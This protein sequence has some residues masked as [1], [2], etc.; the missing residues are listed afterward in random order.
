MRLTSRRATL[1]FAA[2]LVGCIGFSSVVLAEDPAA[3]TAGTGLG[4]ADL[5]PGQPAAADTPP[6]AS[7]SSSQLL[8]SPRALPADAAASEATS[9][10]II[11]RMLG[12]VNQAE[13][14]PT[15][16]TLAEAVH[17]AIRSNPG[18]RAQ[19][20][21]PRRD[22]YTPYGATGAFDPKFRLGAEGNK[23]SAPSASALASGLATTEERSV[24]TDV[25]ISKML[26]SG[27]EFDVSWN[28]VTADTNSVFY[29]INPRY[30]NRLTFSLR[31]PIL[32]NFWAANEN[33]LVLVG[34]S[35]AEESLANFEAELSQFVAGVID[36]YWRYEQ[37]DA[38]LE[39]ARRSVALANE[40]VRDADARVAVGLLA[41]VAVKEAQA[42][43]AARE[44]KAIVAEN[45][46]LVAG[47][48]LQHQVMLGAAENKAAAPILPSEEHNVSKV[49]VDRALSLKT[50][51]ES[52]AEIRGAAYALGS[53]RFEEKRARNALLP[54]LDILGDYSLIGLAGDAK[55]VV[56][57]EG[58]V[59]FSPYD[60]NYGDSL[61][62][63]VNG[64]FHRY[65]VGLE[66]EVPFGN[67]AAKADAAAAEIEVKRA[68]LNL[69]QTVSTVVLDVDRA[70]ADLASAGKRVVASRAARTL[71]EEN[72]RN[73]T[74]RF[75][76]GAVT[77]KDVLDF[78]EKLAAAMASEVRAITDHAL[79]VTRLRLADG[80]LLSRFGIEVENPDA[81]GLPWWYQF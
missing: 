37:A 56:D 16:L 12:E 14:K 31:Q 38:E 71:A 5:P 22:A 10:R 7:A 35:R 80:T 42:D 59:Q 29:L 40:L 70:I 67:A 64:D 63:M 23:I 1:L 66:L 45:D 73:Q 43:A 8:A 32:R 11:E 34:R 79:S 74:R 68:S 44:E 58:N 30:E 65:G 51:I 78:Q 41:P 6:D 4:V 72:L 49:E 28:N 50:A 76:L 53:T 55:P 9:A 19:A 39:V 75:E 54:G 77:T 62:E 26:R 3:E 46:V 57:D 48:V 13:S 25:S 20:E 60:G 69:E 61:S 15:R 27:A 21:I 47:R 17:T 18:I 52:R 33:T 81:P 36:A 24:T 2:T